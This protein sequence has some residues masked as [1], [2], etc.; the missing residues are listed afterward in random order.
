MSDKEILVTIFYDNGMM[1]SMAMLSRAAQ[2]TADIAA[3]AH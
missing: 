1:C 3:G 2:W